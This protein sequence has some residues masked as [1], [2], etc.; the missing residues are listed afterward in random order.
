MNVLYMYTNMY[1][2]FIVYIVMGLDNIASH[3]FQFWFVFVVNAMIFNSLGHAGVALLPNILAATQFLGL[4]FTLLMLFGGVFAGAGQ[5]PSGWYWLYYIN[6]VPKAMAAMA[7]PQ[8]L[9]N[10]NSVSGGCPTVDGFY[11]TVNGVQVPQTRQ[12]YVANFLA[13]DE[14]NNSFA[15]VQWLVLILAVVRTVAILAI[16]FVSHIKR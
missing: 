10:D 4:F 13:L 8:F 14:A 9:C 3:F 7:M 15:E 12:D 5:I 11:S 16:Q 1:S 2:C 6:S